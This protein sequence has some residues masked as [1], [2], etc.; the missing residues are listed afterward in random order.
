MPQVRSFYDVL[1]VSQ[2]ASREMITAAWRVQ[3]QRFHPDRNGGDPECARIMAV[4]NAAYYALSDPDRRREHDEWLAAAHRVAH[5]KRRE[6]PSSSRPHRSRSAGGNDLRGALTGAA[7]YLI[8]VVVLVGVVALL[9]QATD[10]ADPSGL[11]AYEETAA[12]ETSA[13]LSYSTNGAAPTAGVPLPVKPTYV[14]PTEAP[15]GSAWPR[16]AGYVPGYKRHRTDG[17]SSVTIDNTSNDG[18]M[19][20][21]LVAID[22]DKTVPIRHMFVPGASRFT[23]ANVRSGQYDVRYQDLTSGGLSRSEQ[24]EVSQQEDSRGTQ[25]SQITMTLYKV[26]DGNMETFALSP[27]EF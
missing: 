4:V 3:S 18:D 19:F 10:E 6:E 11:P 16:T 25:F 9:P 23:A 14:R 22:N 20:V 17:L 5:R 26:S 1:E 12:S 2:A 8:P 21:K 27:S 7:K 24:F 15:N 13:D